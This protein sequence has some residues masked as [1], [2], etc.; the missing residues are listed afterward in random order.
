MADQQLHHLRN[1][2]AGARVVV[3]A[4]HH[5]N[6]QTPTPAPAPSRPTLPARTYSAPAG[7]LPRHV[8]ASKQPDVAIAQIDE[9]RPLSPSDE[10]PDRNPNAAA[11]PLLT[12]PP[13]LTPTP[14]LRLPQVNMAVVGTRGVGKST[15]VK[16]ALDLKQ[17][18]IA[19]SS[20]KKMSLDGTIYLVRVLEIGIHKIDI[21]DTGRIT[22]P[23]ALGEQALPPIDGVLA[24]FDSADPSS[25]TQLSELIGAL[26]RS[27]NIPF[28]V[29][30][31]KC[32]TPRHSSQH[33]PAVLEQ[34]NRLLAGTDAIQT[35]IRVKESHKKCISTVLRAII[36]RSSDV[37]FKKKHSPSKTRSTYS[38]VPP[39]QNV[40]SSRHHT[41]AQ[42][43]IPKSSHLTTPADPYADGLDPTLAVNVHGAR[44]GR[45]NS[46]PVPPRTPPG[47][48][49]TRAS[50]V[51]VD[52]VPEESSPPRLAPPPKFPSQWRHSASSNAFNSFLDMEDEGDDSPNPLAS[53]VSLNK[54]VK[55][56]V[57][58]RGF[59]F[60]EL[61]DRLLSMP[62]TKQD[63]KFLPVFLCLYRKFAVP[64]RLLMSIIARFEKI[65]TSDAPRLKRYADQLS[66][67][68]VLAQWVSEYPGDFADA[69]TRKRLTTFI[70]DLE[71]H[72]VFAFAAKEMS[73]Y[74][75]KFVED[76]DIAW[77]FIT[78]KSECDNLETF[79]DISDQSSPT[80][81]I[82]QSAD[83]MALSVATIDLNEENV[84]HSS[85]CSNPSNS[86]TINRCGSISS[87]SLKTLMTTEV[88]QREARRLEILPRHSLG[89]S[90]WRIFIETPDEDFAREITRID[91]VMYSSFTPRELV[92]HVGTSS[93]NK[94]KPSSHLE[95]VNR[96]IKGFNHLAYF[97]ASM[98]LLRDKA[99][100]R[101][102]ALEKFVNVAWHLRQMHN[103]N[104]LGAIIAGLNGTP[105]YRL[106]QTRELVSQSAQKHLMSLVILMGTQKSHFAYRLAWENT[107][108]ERIPFLPLHL[109][110]L[111]S[112]EEGNRTLIGDRINWRKFEVM[113]D[114]I[115]GV[116]Q[117]QRTPFPTFSANETVRRLLLEARF[118]G[119]EEELYSRSLTVEPSAV[120]GGGHD[121]KYKR[122][123]WR[124][125]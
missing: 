22:W 44:Y 33:D 118:T 7:E 32:D 89:K 106:A 36:V 10:T 84:D 97:V 38:T 56:K 18:P 52:P 120:I 45:S 43:E 121:T 58:E 31:C 8:R 27:S 65:N 85:Q 125:N 34:A 20:V 53:P 15:F 48:R 14:K 73:S 46:H 111:V 28:L 100:H 13:P 68:N 109:R 70:A 47:S 88:A 92:R 37:A 42:S 72:M 30:A 35:S 87:Q 12:M 91:W 116:Q 81:S 59:T 11:P 51:T 119:D 107:F 112:A 55:G 57:E 16:Y 19:R 40:Y 122:F 63:A 64:G 62:Q 1:K 74:L 113:G 99:K 71:K 102:Q 78:E 23:R 103:Y 61:V 76:D 123:V 82:S 50:A 95:N 6:T 54:T 94:E 110:D 66:I 83:E 39:R 25:L 4:E 75:E 98:V 67:L 86:S 104:S 114:V 24:L 3:V 124:R 2:S 101:A 29:V 41:R 80:T 17:T 21:D 79:L 26:R 77:A 117:S 49:I 69:K 108:T 115:L 96:M 93:E 105:I 90:Q 9:R 5:Q 60:G